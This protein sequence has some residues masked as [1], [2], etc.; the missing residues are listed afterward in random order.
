MKRD[1]LTANGSVRTADL[2]RSAAKLM[3]GEKGG[4]R[5]ARHRQIASLA[6]QFDK[7]ADD[8]DRGSAKA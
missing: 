5:W 3:R 1:L 7:L 6:K 2:L 8:L 4:D